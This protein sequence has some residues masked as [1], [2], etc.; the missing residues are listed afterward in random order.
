MKYKFIKSLTL[1]SL[2]PTSNFALSLDDLSI[3]GYGTVGIAYQGNK[4]V[5]YRNS[6]S[7]DK[8]SQGDISF[9]NYS[10]FGLQLDL[11]ASDKLSFV[12]QGVAS[13]KNSNA[14][15]LDLVWINGK[16]NFTDDSSVRIG[17]MKLATFMYSDIIDVGYS[18]DWIRLPDM[19]SIMPINNYTG[20]EFSHNMK[21]DEFSLS[22]ALHFGESQ[23]HTCSNDPGNGEVLPSIIEVDKIYG[24]SLNFLSD[25]LSLRVGYGKVRL[26]L[27]NKTM[28]NALLGLNALGIPRINESIDKYQIKN[29]PVEYLEVGGKYSFNDSYIVGEYMEMNT[30]TFLASNKS[31]YVGTGYNFEDWS[32][33]I[34]YSIIE[35]TQ[36]YKDIPITNSSTAAAITYTNNVLSAISKSVT[37][38]ELQTT[39]LGL[40]YNL[41]ENSI[42]KL[43]YDRQK[44]FKNHKLNFHFSDD[45]RVDL[46]V[47]SAAIN[48]VF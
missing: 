16:Y 20:I 11:K 37:S 38:V 43:Q 24:G 5:L 22:S 26:T 33:F 17:R 25:N 18:Y 36:N 13:Q 47:Y 42:L 1:L 19:Y 3:H 4:D 14:K 35:S 27:H 2:F 9:A 39:S 23:S 44:E 46:D 32:P 12:A 28:D 29:A 21:F 8:G 45:N 31:W 34:L 30:D 7:M 10:S 6:L 41:T 48:F 15:L 40:R